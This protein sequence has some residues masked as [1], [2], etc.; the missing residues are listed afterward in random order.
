MFA[1]LKELSISKRTRRNHAPS[2][3]FR[4]LLLDRGIRISMDGRGCW[5]DNLFVE[6]GRYVT[7]YNTRRPH[8]SL[9]DQTPDAVYFSPLLLPAS[10]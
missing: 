10:A 2:A 4:E 5:R 7:P 9:T 8:S 3:A 1:T 6:L